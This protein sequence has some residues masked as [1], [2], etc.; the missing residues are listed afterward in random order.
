MK[1]LVHEDLSLAITRKEL[2]GIV[3]ACLNQQFQIFWGFHKG[4]MI[5]HIYNSE[6][7][8]LLTFRRH[9]HYLELLRAQIISFPVLQVL[10][11]SIQ[12]TLKT[13]KRLEQKRKRTAREIYQE[14]DYYLMVLHEE[15]TTN[16]QMSVQE[17]KHKLEELR[18]EQKRLAKG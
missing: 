15:L 6:E 5:L 12:F 13:R 17:I 3:Q 1:K 10:D 16:N 7:R 14:I 2:K 18:R 4:T 11:F 8:N 9:K